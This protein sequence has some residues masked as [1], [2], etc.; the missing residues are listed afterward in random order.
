MPKSSANLLVYRS[1]WPTPASGYSNHSWRDRQFTALRM[2]LTSH[3]LT[4]SERV[5]RI[6]I[7]YFTSSNEKKKKKSLSSKHHWEEAVVV[8]LARNL[9][10]ILYRKIFLSLLKQ[11]NMDH[12][13]QHFPNLKRNSRWKISLQRSLPVMQVN[14]VIMQ[15][16]LCQCC[17]VLWITIKESWA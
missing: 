6:V 11:R 1:Q 16:P 10:K 5:L 4:G 7:N 15:H 14:Y 12:K 9:K 3:L 2:Y 17:F 8:L 13:L